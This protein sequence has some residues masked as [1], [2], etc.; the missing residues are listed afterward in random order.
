M[1]VIFLIGIQCGLYP[2]WVIRRVGI[3][4]ALKANAYVLGVGD[5]VLAEDSGISTNTLEIAAVNLN[6]WLVG[7]HLHEDTSL[8]RIEAGTYL[9]VIALTILVSVQT[10]I[11][12][13]ASRILDLVEL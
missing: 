13:I 5:A 10:E 1:A 8:G 2:L 9:C 7:K 3:L 4:L 12:V 6:T 11:V